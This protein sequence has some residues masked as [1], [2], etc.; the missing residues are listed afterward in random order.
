MEK[1]L[2]IITDRYSGLSKKA[3]NLLAGTLASHL[4]YTVL[5]VLTYERATD[6][7]LAEST[8]IAVGCSKTHPILA[9]YEKLGLISVP[10]AKDGYSL[11][12]GKKPEMRNIARNRAH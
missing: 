1:P 8:V 5:P 6:D 2:V 3:V 10:D 9:K 12:V 4:G 7:I 11:F